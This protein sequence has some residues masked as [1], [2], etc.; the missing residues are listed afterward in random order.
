VSKIKRG[1]HAKEERWREEENKGREER[2]K[3]GREERCSN[4]MQP[5]SSLRIRIQRLQQTVEL[6]RL[7]RSPKSFGRQRSR[8]LSAS[9]SSSSRLGFAAWDGDGLNACFSDEESVGG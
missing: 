1:M 6:I 3:E 9:S 8:G 5:K 7:G 2:K 4:P